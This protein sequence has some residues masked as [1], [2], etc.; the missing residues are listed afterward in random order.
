M[1]KP[2]HHILVCRSFRSTGEP[3]GACHKKGDRSLLQYLEEGILDRGL[4]VLVSSTGC[5]KVCEKGPVLVLQP[6]NAWFGEVDEETVDA[7][8]DDLSEG[9]CTEAHRIA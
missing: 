4:D 9:R 2:T 1:K 3:Q 6:E 7:I 5:L 8:L